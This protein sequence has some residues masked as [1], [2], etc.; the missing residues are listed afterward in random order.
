M[1]PV[2]IVNK[3]IPGGECHEIKTSNSDRDV[4]NL[5]DKSSVHISF[6]DQEEESGAD[7]LRKLGIPEGAKFVCIIVRDSAYLEEL[8]YHSYRDGNI[9]QY[10]L[11][12][13]YLANRGYYVIRMGAKVKEPIDSTHSKIIDYATSGSRS[14]FM[15]IYLGAKCSF[16]IST[17]TGFDA[18][19]G[20]FRKPIAFVTVP[21]S[22][23]FTFSNKYISITKHHISKDNGRE[24]SFSEICSMNLDVSMSSSDYQKKNIELVEN[25]PEEI[26]DLVVEMVDRLDGVWVDSPDDIK[27]RKLFQS[28]FSNC[29]LSNGENLH[30]KFDSYIGA[31]FLRQNSHL[32][33]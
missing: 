8:S 28:I 17:S 7:Q 9:Q 26:R 10:V 33:K 23:I 19:P 4:H 27:N 12:C 18:I 1:Y 2:M 15:D 5:F 30:G 29:Q 3:L 24:L 13:E 20:I 22:Y 6:T 11:A 14:E 32:L 31:L 25:S 21:F 16:C